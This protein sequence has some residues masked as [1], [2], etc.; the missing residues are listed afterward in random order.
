MLTV[1][2]GPDRQL[3]LQ[4]GAKL[5]N[6]QDIQRCPQDRGNLRRDYDTAA[7]QT[8]HDDIR[9]GIVPQVLQTRRQLA[10]GLGSVFEDRQGFVPF[11]SVRR[12]SLTRSR[13]CSWRWGC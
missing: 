11:W 8:Q 12:R 2:H 4:G 3:R 6:N 13:T 9:S 5:A 10:A 1:G 7:W